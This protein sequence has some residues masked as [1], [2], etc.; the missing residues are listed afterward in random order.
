MVFLSLAHGERVSTVTCWPVLFCPKICV[1]LAR[2]PSGR[3]PGSK[4]L[5]P[6]AASSLLP[7]V[8]EPALGMRVCR[9]CRDPVVA[10]VTQASQVVDVKDRAA[11]STRLYLVHLSA[12]RRLAAFTH[13]PVLQQLRHQRSALTVQGFH[14]LGT[15]S[16]GHTSKL[17][18][19]SQTAPLHRVLSGP[20]VA[21]KVGG[22][23][24]AVDEAQVFPY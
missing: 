21:H 6:A 3:L 2:R 14:L 16:E 17:G 9:V 24:L 22:C 8:L 20:A 1:N 23:K 10:L 11:S 15:C 18:L 5:L 19:V 13:G 4:G 12:V 7:G